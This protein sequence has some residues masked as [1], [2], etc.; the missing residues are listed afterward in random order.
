MGQGDKAR[1]FGLEPELEVP[2]LTP[3]CGRNL[4]GPAVQASVG[5]GGGACQRGGYRDAGVAWKQLPPGLLGASFPLWL[6]ANVALEGA[7]CHL[8]S[9]VR[10][11]AHA[12]NQREERSERGQRVMCPAAWSSASLVGGASL[13][14]SDQTGRPL[15]PV[16][17]RWP[18]RVS[19]STHLLH[20]VPQGCSFL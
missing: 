16:P 5:E 13:G 6:R 15:C 11:S 3:R 17:P 10:L 2:A 7:D 8:L 20:F 12:E 9:V 1:G 4:S 18:C 14:P 19:D